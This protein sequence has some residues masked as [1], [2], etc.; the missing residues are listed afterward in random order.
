MEQKHYYTDEKNAQIVIALLKAHGIKRVIASPGTTHMAFLGSIQ[1]D[2]WFEIWSAIDER[3]AA[4]MA[5]GMAAETREPVVLTCTGATA[6]RNYFPALTEAYYRKLPI[7]ALTAS[8]LA[9]HNGNLYSQMIDRSEQPKDTVK[10]SL[11]CPPVENEREFKECELA[12]NKAILELFRHGGGVVHINLEAAYSPHFTT[13]E[14]PPVRVIRRYF[15]DDVLPEIPAHAKIAVFIANH[16]PFSNRQKK[17]LD[18]FLLSHNAVAL[19]TATSSWIGARKVVGSLV[20]AQGIKKNPRYAD[21]HPDLVIFIGDACNDYPMLRY[22]S[23]LSP[24][25]YVS[26]EGEARDRFETLEKVFEMPETY[27]FEHYSNDIHESDS[28]FKAWMAADMFVRS[29]IPELPFSN[30]WIAQQT[31]PKLPKDAVLHIGLSTSLQSWTAFLHESTVMTYCNEGGC[32]IDG[33]VS[34]LIGASLADTQKMFY[35]VVGDLTFFYDLNS[36]GNRHVS[37][38]FRL[39]VVNNGC[40]SLFHTS[41]YPLEQFTEE[42]DDYMAAGGHFGRRSPVLVKHYACDLGF[43]YLSASCKEEFLKNLDAFCSVDSDKP[44]IFE[45]FVDTSDDR[46]A[47]G[48]RTSID[49]Y[50]APKT[51]KGEIKKMMPQRVKNAIRGFMQ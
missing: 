18:G 47:W 40:G 5:V 32:G 46:T 11:A 27:F 34:T 31:I 21:L 6:S 19:C 3:H 15:V 1:Y 20:C 7:L 22:L 50:V 16:K 42:L 14:L 38:N 41:G 35:G 4:Y 9:S 29:K 13:E 24:T 8:Q 2:P 49:N 28:L 39:M 44:I 25:W 33:C 48:L 30:L 36:L 37:N 26:V 43:K 23:G 12:V 17:A 10:Y 51:L 45:N